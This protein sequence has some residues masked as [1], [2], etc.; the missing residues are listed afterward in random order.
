MGMPPNAKA[1]NNDT[2]NANAN[3][4]APRLTLIIDI[5]ELLP[6]SVTHNETVGVSSADQG[7]GKRRVVNSHRLP[8]DVQSLF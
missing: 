6:V 8:C 2:A 3:P 7:G 4:S 5:G 1:T